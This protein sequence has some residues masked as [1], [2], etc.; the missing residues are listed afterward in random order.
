MA[1]PAESKTMQGHTGVEGDAAHLK[2]FQ[3]RVHPDFVTILGLIIAIGLI[4]MALT[5]GGSPQAFLNGP[6]LLIVVGGTAA[7]TSMSFSGA[8]LRQ[9]LSIVGNAMFRKVHDPSRLA[10]SLMH[11]AEIARK[12]G[13]LALNTLEGECSKDPKLL[14]GLRLAS[15]GYSAE[16]IERILSHDIATMKERHKRSADILRRAAEVAPAMGLIGTLVGLVQMLSRLSDPS[17]IGPSMAVALLTTFYGALLG[18][19]LLSPLAAKL[20]RNSQEEI[21]IKSL[22]L[23]GMSSIA[24]QENPRRLEHLL[25]KELPPAKRI[26]HF[27]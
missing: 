25:N 19:V 9:M 14:D 18:T 8:E 1:R 27:D 11:L 20:E 12:R 21:V 4:G 3:P 10:K 16:D 24:R 5:L 26:Q 22:I 13:I 7:V 2:V 23:H 15:D 6:A 17:S